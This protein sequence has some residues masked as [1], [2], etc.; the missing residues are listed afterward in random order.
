MADPQGEHPAQRQDVVPALVG[1]IHQH[2]KRPR[3]MER[4]TAMDL[5]AIAATAHMTR[6]RARGVESD[7][8][9]RRRGI[10]DLALI[11]AMRDCLLERSEAAAL[12][13]DDLTELEDGSGCLRIRRPRAGQEREVAVG[14]RVP[15]DHEVVE[16]D[17]GAHQ[18]RTRRCSA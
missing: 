2:L 17:E 12:T 1:L 7:I 13:W 18:A 16:G 3:Q 9:A 11:G 14:V 15:P 10:T 4:L 8:A 6:Q 5:E